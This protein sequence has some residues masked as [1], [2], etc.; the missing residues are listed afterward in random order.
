MY[1]KHGGVQVLFNPTNQF[2]A[3]R[4]LQKGPGKG[5]REA[6]SASNGGILAQ[7]KRI[8]KDKKA[9][10]SKIKEKK[11]A[12][13]AASQEDGEEGMIVSEA[14]N[15]QMSD[16]SSDSDDA[17]NP[18]EKKLIEQ[19]EKYPE[20]LKISFKKPPSSF[21]DYLEPFNSSNMYSINN[22]LSKK[23]KDLLC[24]QSFPVTLYI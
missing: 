1:Q 18:T 11:A 24:E 21:L 16:G 15:S 10:D 8:K 12:Q 7:S 23:S 20:Y 4:K 5:S 2:K 3:M 9:A 14:E 22:I 19:Y 17:I 13:Q 6:K